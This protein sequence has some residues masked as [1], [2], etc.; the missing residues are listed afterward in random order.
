M[1]I[2]HDKVGKRAEDGQKGGY[3]QYL[4][5][6]NNGALGIFDGT[7]DVLI[8]SHFLYA[9]HSLICKIRHINQI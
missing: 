1:D 5:G 2:F 8:T 9:T 6:S 3:I 4:P 7:A